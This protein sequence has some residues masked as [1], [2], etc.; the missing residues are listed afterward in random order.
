MQ[1]ARPTLNDV[2]VT[3]AGKHCV[4]DST[5]RSATATEAAAASSVS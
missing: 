2:F 4:D 1:L 5:G 3:L